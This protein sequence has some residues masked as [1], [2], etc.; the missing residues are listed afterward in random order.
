MD[1]TI[2]S[3]IPELPNYIIATIIHKELVVSTMGAFSPLQ[4]VICNDFHLRGSRHFA[5]ALE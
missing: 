3:A 1:C 5:F 2:Q 4:L